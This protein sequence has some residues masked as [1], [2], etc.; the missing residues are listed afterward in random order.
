MRI[1]GLQKTSLIDFPGRVAAVIF[2]QGCPFRCDFCHNPELVIPEQFAQQI[3]SAQIWQFLEKRVG[4][5]D[6]VAISG[7]DP[8]IQPD[9]PQFLEKLKKLGYQ[10]KLDTT[11][12]NPQLLQNLI[13]QRLVDYVAMDVKA[14]LD[15]YQV[16]THSPIPAKIIQRSID[17]LIEAGRQNQL[18]YEFRTTIV[19][20]QLTQ[21]D[22]LQIGQTIKG[23]KNYY[24]QR[25]IPA[26]TLN[27][28]FAHKKTYSDKILNR[29]QQ[30]LEK[31]F[32]Q[33][34]AIR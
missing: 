25:F 11:G 13:D 21:D 23:A 31:Q 7:G 2:T 27:P 22:I 34:C 8:S 32:V 33:K 6:G 24:L 18:E 29:L 14:P 19:T 15:K 1:A 5:L 4:Q 30:Q 10:T 12:I 28:E 3:S 26:H 9:L 20:E 17:L 16:I